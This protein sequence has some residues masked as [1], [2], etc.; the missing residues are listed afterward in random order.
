MVDTV[1]VLVIT[2]P[3][4]DCSSDLDRVHLPA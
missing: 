4:N 3:M 1:R 2:P